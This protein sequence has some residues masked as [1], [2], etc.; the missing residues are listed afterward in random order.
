MSK[1][2]R[3]M[4]G[5]GDEYDEGYGFDSSNRGKMNK[6]LDYTKIN[7]LLDTL[8]NYY[9]IKFKIKAKNMRLEERE[10]R[11]K[12]EEQKI[13]KTAQHV[14]NL[15]AQSR[16]EVDEDGYAVPDTFAPSL[17]PPRTSTVA[18]NL[19]DEEEEV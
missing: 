14:G 13:G 1:K 16:G 9:T 4:G 10:A 2:G 15:R 8:N 5:T 6:T 11:E 18:T 3:Q 7:S 19:F 12:S 17:P